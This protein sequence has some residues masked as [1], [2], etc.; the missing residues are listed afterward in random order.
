MLRVSPDEKLA[1]LANRR[2]QHGIVVELETGK[3][4]M[5]LDRGNYHHQHCNFPAAFIEMDGRLRLVH[6]T[7]WNRL[8]VSDPHTGRRFTDR[9]DPVFGEDRKR[10]EHYLD[11]F[12]CGLTVSPNQEYIADNGWVWHPVGVVTTWSLRRWLHENV[13]ESEDGPTRKA[14][15]WRDYFWDGPLC[16]IGDDRLAVWGLGEDE[17]WLLPAV[18]IFDAVTGNEER[19]FPGPK[20]SLEYDRYLFSFQVDEG[21]SVW[22]VTSGERLL[23]EPSF[24]PLRYHRGIKAF[25]TVLPDGRFR[26][27]RL[28]GSRIDPAWLRRQ[29]GTVEKL[30]RAFEQER[31][32]ARLGVLADA[33]EEVGCQDAELLAHCRRGEPHGDRCWVVD[34]LLGEA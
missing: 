21:T 24:C 7:K 9:P 6:G 33:L 1:V 13:W 20:G 15:C 18:R 34:L 12:H 11:Y 32:F 29:G 16:W 3:T 30:A 26:I 2:G 27:S 17:E 19:W 10:P 4:T 23:R 5:S 31:D 8:D 25:L 22:D 28:R 14:V